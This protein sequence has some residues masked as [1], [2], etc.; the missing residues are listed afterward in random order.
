MSMY[1]PNKVLSTREY[2]TVGKRPIRHDGHD[3][4]TGKA[5]YGA[6]IRLPGLLYARTLQSPHAH[7]RI[8]S[9]DP[10]KALALPGVRA[11]VTAADL[12]PL[13]AD[14]ATFGFTLCNVLAR[15]KALYKGHPV[16][17]VCATSIHSAEEALDL[18]AVEYEVLPAVFTIEDAM[19][20]GAPVLHEALPAHSPVAGD[21]PSKNIANRFEFE[22]GDLREGFAAAEVV[23]ERETTTVPVHQ[24]Y[25]EP[26][27]GTA[28]W[29]EDGSLTLWSSSQGHFSIRDFT[30]RALGVPVAKVKA[31][32]LEI[33]G[34]F[35]AKLRAYVEPV[36]AALA[37][38]AHAPVKLTMT[39]AEVFE[40]TGPTSGT[41]IRVK[42]GATRDGR[43][44]AAEAVMLYTAG[45]FP[46]SSVGGGSRCIMTG[47]D[48]PNARIE[49]FD[50]VVNSP[51]TAAYRAPGS[52]AAALAFETALDE[53][54]EKLELDPIDL[55]L[56]N[57]ARE[58]TRRVFGT[59]MPK[60]GFVEVLQA[61]KDHPHYQS[62]IE[63]PYRGRGVAS[64][65]WGNGTGPSSA[66]ATLNIDGSVNLSEGSPD[67]GGTRAAVAQ[68]FAEV[69]G[70]PVEQINPQ[71][72]D[73]DSIGYTSNSAG[74]GVTFKTG[75]AAY[76][77]ACEMRRQL[78]AR[79]A[80][81]W[82]VEVEKVVYE[83]GA[84]RCVD[85]DQTLSFKEL[86]TC[87]NET[88]GPIVASAGVNPGGAGPTLATH[89][90]D[91][92][93]D[94][95]TGKIQI[96]RYTAIQDAGKAIHP[97]YVE[98][99]IQGGAAQGIG[100]ALNEE[101]FVDGEGQMLNSSFLDYRM[102]TALDLPMID[103]VIVEVHNPGHPYGV[104][105]VGEVPIVP[106]LAAIANAIHDAIGVRIDDLPLNPARILAALK[107]TN[108]RS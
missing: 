36:A 48:I 91:L 51:K 97:S 21:T 45:A 10:G 57:S 39:R 64:G 22:L 75:W 88:G 47:Y 106:P 30:A 33:G 72:L 93:I 87:Q 29:H 58:D 7:A 60:V 71:I 12:A 85:Q 105:G 70:I 86:A 82:E 59:L 23:V 55:R 81:L 69:L 13:P 98:G 19:A 95:D 67:I 8:R 5:H 46:G 3:K 94:P 100:W 44:T 104:R 56:K 77:A 17:A 37:R 73:T 2:N 62:K 89:I 6:D 11:V 101:Y 18:I 66:V 16:A 38:K 25:I 78:V 35:G 99:Q 108:G 43:L 32:P 84:A 107:N 42:L 9:I 27:S 92:E 63:G 102:P 24:G 14:D 90:V 74:S 50:I 96:L 41:Q 79:A 53:L 15:D 4:V 34:G 68:Q 52:P 83:N 80:E 40:R 49:G 28:M 76:E 65:Y 20:E 26:H 54:A 1:E 103:T 31:V 61:A